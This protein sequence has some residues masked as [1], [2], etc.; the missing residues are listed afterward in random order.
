MMSEALEKARHYEETQSRKISATERPLF[1]LTPM[2]GWM[3][4]P[5]G[6]SYYKG[7]YHMFYQ[8][9][10]YNSQWAPMHW[11]HAVSEDLLHWSYMSIV[12]ENR[13][14]FGKMW[15][16]PDLFSLDGKD[17][18]ITSPQDMLAEGLSSKNEN[19]P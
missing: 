15:E 12:D 6:F 4:D 16:C 3:N 19:V 14:R 11:G 17:V 9:H 10:P 2:V 7:K 5:N 18:V 1:H 8:Y 13:N